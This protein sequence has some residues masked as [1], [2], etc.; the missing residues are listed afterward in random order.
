MKHPILAT[1]VLLGLSSLYAAAQQPA[2][3]ATAEPKIALWSASFGESAQVT[4]NVSSIVSVSMHPYM[5]N[6]VIRITEVTVDTLGNNTLRFYYIHE[7]GGSSSTV[8]G[9]AGEVAR[10]AQEQIRREV[11]QQDSAADIPSVKF[12]EGA[13]AHS[14]EYQV[15]SL[16]ELEAL[17]KSLI[18]V[19]NRDSKRRTNFK[20]NSK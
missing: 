20:A 15:S 10:T 2:N 9:M 16:S 6:G 3:T 8:G 11:T 5:L 17:Y 14:I 18:S 4:L 7:N 19:W 1:T 12:P 13:Y